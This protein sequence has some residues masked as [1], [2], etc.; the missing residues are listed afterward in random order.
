MQAANIRSFFFVLYRAACCL[1]P[2]FVSAG[3]GG[4]GG[5]GELGVPGVLWRRLPASLH[6]FRSRLSRDRGG[7]RQSQ[8]AAA[9]GV[10]RVGAGLYERSYEIKFISRPG[11]DFQT[12][13]SVRFCFSLSCN[14]LVTK[15]V[16]YCTFPIGA[17]GFGRMLSV[18]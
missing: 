16:C 8:H 17:S 15:I 4:G 18:D 13:D 3:L 1:L 2:F 7:P 11:R 5:V 9:V 12:T 6:Y 10:S 14:A